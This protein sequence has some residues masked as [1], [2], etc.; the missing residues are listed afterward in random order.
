MLQEPAAQQQE[1][2]DTRGLGGSSGVQ[3]SASGLGAA[4]IPPCHSYSFQRLA[5]GLHLSVREPCSCC[6]AGVCLRERYPG[7]HPWNSRDRCRGDAFSHVR[8]MSCGVCASGIA[9]GELHP[10]TLCTRR[11]ASGDPYIGVAQLHLQT[12]DFIVV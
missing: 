5:H 4:T 6:L 8:M 3:C 12:Q 11:P 9:C 2:A 10:R 7:S 1:E